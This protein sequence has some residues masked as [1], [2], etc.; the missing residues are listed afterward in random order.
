MGI[1]RSELDVLGWS[2]GGAA[3]GVKE[4]FEIRV[5]LSYGTLNTISI[6]FPVIEGIIEKGND[7][8]L[9]RY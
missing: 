2:D 5:E 1:P 3:K 7:G 8:C 4:L 9:N 6:N